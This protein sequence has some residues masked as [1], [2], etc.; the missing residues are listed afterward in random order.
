MERTVLRAVFSG[1]FPF[2]ASKMP[3][4]GRGFFFHRKLTPLSSKFT[5]VHA[6]RIW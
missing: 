2:F 1:C 5:V 4:P 6:L 3:R